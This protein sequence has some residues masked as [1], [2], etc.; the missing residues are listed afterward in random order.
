MTILVLE[1]AY[2]AEEPT[3]HSGLRA[4]ELPALAQIAQSWNHY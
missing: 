4:F 2:V 3:M 1:H